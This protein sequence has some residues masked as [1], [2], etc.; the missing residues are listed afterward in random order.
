MGESIAQDSN[1][2]LQSA[3]KKFAYDEK[4]AK[5]LLE[6]HK[7]SSPLTKDENGLPKVF[8]HGS[9][10]QFETFDRDKTGLGYFFTEQREL[11]EP[12]KDDKNLIYPSFLK[13]KKVFDSAN[14]TQA[15]WDAY[16]DFIIQRAGEQHKQAIEKHFKQWQKDLK[17][18]GA[19]PYTLP[20]FFLWKELERLGVE[21]ESSGRISFLNYG[22]ELENKKL[23]EF[24]QS[25]GYDAMTHTMHMRGYDSEVLS[26]FDSNQIKHIENRGVESESGRKYFNSSSPNIFHSNPHLGAGLLGGSVAGVEQDENGNITFSPEKF[27]LGLLGGAAGSKA[28]AKGLEWRARKVAKSY[29]NI[30]KDNPQLMQEIARRDLHTYATATT[31]N[32]LTRFLHNNKLFDINPQLFA[33]EKALANEAYAP[34]KARLERAKELEAK[35]AKEIEIWEQTGWYKDKDQRWKFEISQSGGELRTKDEF[36]RPYKRAFLSKILQDDE[37]FNAYPKLENIRVIEDKKLGRGVNAIYDFKLKDIYI[38]NLQAKEAK[39]TLY[40][41]LQ[42]A[43]QDIEGFAYGFKDY[44]TS[45]ENFHKYAIQHGEVEARNVESRMNLPTKKDVQTLKRAAKNI[46]KHIENLKTSDYEEWYKNERIN[47]EQSKKKDFLA[48]AQAAQEVI[49]QGKYTDH[50]HETMDTPLKDTIAEATMHG[51]ALSKKLES[52]FLDSSGKIDFSKINAQPLPKAT[53][54]NVKQFT[55]SFE[56]RQ[57]KYGIVKTPYKDVVVDIPRAYRHFYQNTHN[58]NRNYLKGAFFDILQKPMFIAEQET[59]KGLST[60]FY[61]VYHYGKDKIGVFGIGID[62]NGEIE[63]KTMYADIKQNRLQE[64]IR[65]DDENIKYINLE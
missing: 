34:H 3:M 13:I 18:E 61:K 15:E 56:N 59:D 35:G 17:S 46:D 64:M 16:K 32:A 2:M 30:A 6:W 65:L 20:T 1:A 29:P 21:L 49:N 19:N 63:Y 48:K 40:H 10:N 38:K 33:G 7:D 60:Y 50:P 11:A 39:I 58:T 44:V 41:E 23:V 52:S 47:T 22:S 24:L 51:E 37:L 45:D 62:K 28:V 43:I 5:D 9:E 42:H 8:Y 53:F 4:K 12:F 36:G 26:V 14:P 55:E 54:K 27:A 57:G 31:H 25:R